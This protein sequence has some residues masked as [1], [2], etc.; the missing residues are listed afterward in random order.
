MGIQSEER[1]ID[2]VKNVRISRR[3]LIAIRI[4]FVDWRLKNKLHFDIVFLIKSQLLLE[5]VIIKI[6]II[7]SN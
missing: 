1:R 5:L 7:Y 2:N 3:L 6:K 4:N